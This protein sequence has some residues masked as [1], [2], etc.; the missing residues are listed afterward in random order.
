MKT[1]EKWSFHLSAVIVSVTGL[2]YFYMK[3]LMRGEDPLSVINHP[4]QPQMLKLHLLA[5]P[6]LLFVTGAIFSSHISRKL[7]KRHL[8]NKVSGWTLLFSFAAMS[9]SR[10]L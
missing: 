5:A 2:V 8:Q 9:V 6:F 1:W 4:L 7:K 10:Y 3:Y